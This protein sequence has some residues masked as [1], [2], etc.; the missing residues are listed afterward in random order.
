MTREETG[1]KIARKCTGRESKRVV[2]RY[3]ARNI[4]VKES[5][6]AINDYFNRLGLIIFHAPVVSGVFD[7][8]WS[9]F[10]R[11]DSVDGTTARIEGLESVRLSAHALEAALRSPS[12]CGSPDMGSV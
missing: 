8:C 4:V 11:C 7:V 5:V 6:R 1:V 10:L 12:V 2:H 9:L 3:H